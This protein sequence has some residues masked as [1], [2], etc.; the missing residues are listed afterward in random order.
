MRLRNYLSR[1][2]PV[3]L[4]SIRM[5]KSHKQQR[6]YMPVDKSSALRNQ[7]RQIPTGHRFSNKKTTT[8]PEKIMNPKSCLRWQLT[9]RILKTV[10]LSQNVSEKMESSA[11]GRLIAADQAS[12]FMAMTFVHI[13][14]GLVL[15]QMMSD[16]NSSDLAPQ[17]QEMSVENV[18]SGLTDS[19][20]QGLEFIFS[21]LL[22]EYY[23]PAYGHAEENNNDQAPNASFQED[24][25][26]NPFC[27]RYPLEQVRGNPT[28]PVSNKT[29]ACHSPE[30]VYVHVTARKTSRQTIWHD[31]CTA[32]VVYE[33]Q[34]GDKDQTVIR[35]TKHDWCKRLCQGRAHKS[36]PIYQMDVKTA[37]LNGPLKEEV[38]VAQPEGFVDP[39][40]PEK[41]YLLR[42]A[43]YG[44]KKGAKK[45]G[46][47]R[48]WL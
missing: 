4:H 2:N 3:P 20:K 44:L 29:T 30:N 19:C 26:I 8:V 25:F 43:L 28:M 22:E 39:D 18:S 48:A 46:P 27:T 21:P 33:A 23:N 42:K 17:R 37:F 1:L 10:G 40:H 45:G 15:H 9:G 11:K 35:S 47:P 36:F 31:D 24:E 12:V 6:R 7:K 5:Q 13:S 41:V 34:E 38:Y 32:K 14:S 16:H